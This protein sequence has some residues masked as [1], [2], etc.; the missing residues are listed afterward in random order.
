VPRTNGAGGKRF[1]NRN[2]IE[3]ITE[4]VRRRPRGR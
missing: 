4:Q 1:K 3:K 2:I